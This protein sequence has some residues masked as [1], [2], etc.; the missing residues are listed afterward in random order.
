MGKNKKVETK[1]DNAHINFTYLDNGLVKCEVFTNFGFDEKPAIAT[2]Y[3]P[4]TTKDKFGF[5][6]SDIVRYRL[7][8]DFAIEIGHYSVMH[9]T[10]KVN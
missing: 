6:P 1:V 4:G 10:Q 8:H 9:L 5:I 3:V 2:F 7:K